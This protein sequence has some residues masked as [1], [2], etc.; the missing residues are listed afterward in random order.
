MTIRILSIVGFILSIL[1]Y[2]FIVR[3]RWTGFIFWLIS[4]VLWMAIDIHAGLYEQAAMFA[5]FTAYT[6]RGIIKWRAAPAGD[7]GGER[8]DRKEVDNL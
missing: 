4:N 5:V 2:E 7:D 6:I 1:G 3:K 8:H